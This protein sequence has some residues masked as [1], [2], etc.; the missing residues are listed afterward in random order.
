MCPCTHPHPTHRS[1]LTSASRYFVTIHP[2][3]DI[4]FIVA[5][6]TLIDE[7]FQDQKE[8]NTAF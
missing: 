7:I 3:V 6:A 2:G 1:K 4:C 8:V 5:L